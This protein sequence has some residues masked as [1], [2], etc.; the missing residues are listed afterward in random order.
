M[1][2][3]SVS[4]S[5]APWRGAAAAAAAARGRERA[6]AP[7]TRLRIGRGPLRVLLGATGLLALWIVMWSF[8]ILGVA[9]PAAQLHRASASQAV[10]AV[11]K[12]EPQGDRGR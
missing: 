11:A 5:A 6:S 8:F 2:S 7:V 4:Y 12:A 9:A 3:S 1:S 10:T